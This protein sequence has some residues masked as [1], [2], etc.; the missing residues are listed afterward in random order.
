MNQPSKSDEAIALLKGAVTTVQVNYDT[1]FSLF[2]AIQHVESELK[3]IPG[4]E[5]AVAGP[6]PETAKP[7]CP[8]NN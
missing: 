1:R 5:L 2:A 7:S 4:L 3:R 6:Q 8:V